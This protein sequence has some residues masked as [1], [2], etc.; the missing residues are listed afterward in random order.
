M[1]DFRSN[2]RGHYRAAKMIEFI[3]SSAHLEEE[4]KSLEFT[5]GYYMSVIPNIP[6]ESE[7]TK[8]KLQLGLPL[9]PTFCQIVFSIEHVAG[10][11]RLQQQKKGQ[12]RE[13]MKKNEKQGRRGSEL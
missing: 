12:K 3:C 8:V 13:G 11:G 9:L 7:Y 1:A 5:S 6:C 10:A 4:R 2:K